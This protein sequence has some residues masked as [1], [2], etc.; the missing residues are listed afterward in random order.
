MGHV[1]KLTGGGGLITGTCVLF[2]EMALLSTGG[3]FVF[4]SETPGIGCVLI[5]LGGLMIIED[6]VSLGCEVEAELLKK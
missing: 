6:R 1:G 4:K 5:R 3:L 2:A